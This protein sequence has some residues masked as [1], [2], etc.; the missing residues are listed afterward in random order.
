ML[1]EVLGARRWRALCAP[2]LRVACPPPSVSAVRRSR[3]E[4]SSAPMN[5]RRCPV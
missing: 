2:R 1:V 4:G 5:V 3:G